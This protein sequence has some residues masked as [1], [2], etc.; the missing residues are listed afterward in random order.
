M[1]LTRRALLGTGAALGLATAVAGCNGGGSGGGAASD[2]LRFTFWGPDFYQKFT[3]EMVDL[4][5]Q[6]NPL[7]PGVHRAC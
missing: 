1:A 6:A 3:R 7:H 4:F 2:Q 5:T